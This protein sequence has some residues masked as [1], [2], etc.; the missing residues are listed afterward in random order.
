MRELD[1][2]VASGIIKI[3]GHIRERFTLSIEVNLDK[4]LSQDE[5]NLLL[6]EMTELDPSLE[7]PEESDQDGDE[8]VPYD[9][10]HPDRVIRGRMPTLELIHEHFARLFRQTLTS[11]M[12]RPIGV[13]GRSTEFV[14][15]KDFMKSVTYPTS[16]SIFRLSPLR[17]NALMVMERPLAYAF[18]DMLFGGSGI[19]DTLRP[20]Q[21][22][23]N[24]EMRMIEKIVNSALEDLQ[25]AWLPV[26]PLKMRF[27]RMESHPQFIHIAP[28]T[29][30]VVITTFDIE[31][32]RTPMTLSI[33][34]PYTMLDS[35]RSKLNAGYQSDQLE[36][37]NAVVKRLTGSLLQTEANL[38]IYLGS[39]KM[40]LRKFLNLKVGE[41]ILLDQNS[42]EPLEVLVDS[43]PKFKGT[44]GA[45]KGRR[46]LK[47]TEMIY[48][49][50]IDQSWL[51]E[52]AAD[53]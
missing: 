21:D 10:T 4:I 36:V 45:Y 39:S 30:I 40:S 43:V 27:V 14:N 11:H 31:L 41:H 2:L 47:L 49:P 19:L 7:G 50:R 37:N 42:E 3:G 12:R 32:H 34:M 23:T 35:I 53:D 8:I 22:F 5:V 28:P 17:G 6:K 52:S 20:L 46:A 15:F 16:L 9:L 13:T 38:K 1:S 44:Q 51:E 48:E 24:I 26:V 29:E 18:V 25:K 33:C